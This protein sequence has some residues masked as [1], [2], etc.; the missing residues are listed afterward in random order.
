MPEGIV[1][2]ERGR[3]AVRY[4]AVGWPEVLGPTF[5]ISKKPSKKTAGRPKAGIEDQRGF[6]RLRI[7][8]AVHEARGEPLEAAIIAAMID[9][10]WPDQTAAEI[11]RIRSRFRA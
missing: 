9:L 5:V 10:D 7:A 3:H 1:R 6:L 2:V 4:W 8:T 11:E